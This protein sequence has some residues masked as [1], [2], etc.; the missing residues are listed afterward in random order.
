M[1]RLTSLGSQSYPDPCSP[2]SRSLTRSKPNGDPMERHACIRGHPDPAVVEWS[3]TTQ[4]R[5][6]PK[7]DVPRPRLAAADPHETHSTHITYITHH[8]S[9]ITHS[10]HIIAHASPQPAAFPT[11]RDGIL[12]YAVG[13]HHATRAPLRRSCMLTAVHSAGPCHVSACCPAGRPPPAR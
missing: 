3:V 5:N 12:T 11:S 13:Q 7:S 2:M 9:H 6:T 8:T 4:N 1:C 10:T